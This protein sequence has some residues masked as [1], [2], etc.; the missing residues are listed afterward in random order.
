MNTKGQYRPDVVMVVSPLNGGI[1]GVLMPVYR[2]WW[3]IWL[4]YVIGFREA[5]VHV[6]VRPTTGMG[7]ET[8]Q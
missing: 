4:P 2:K 7:A 5:R 6:W 1:D 8:L 3:Q